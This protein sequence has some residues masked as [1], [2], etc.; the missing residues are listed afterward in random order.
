MQ[1]INYTNSKLIVESGNLQPGTVSW[2]S[3]SNIAIIKYWGKHGVQLPRNP[4]FSFTLSEA[5]SKTSLRYEAK[6][7]FNHEISLQFLFHGQPQPSFEEKIKKYF[8]SLLPYF[9][10]IQQLHFT[11]SSE[12]SFPHSAG[13]ASSASG[14]R[15]KINALLV[16]ALLVSVAIAVWGIVDPQGLGEMSSSIVAIQFESRGWFIMLEASAL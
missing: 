5:H 6:K 12:N 15:V 16:S 2:Q 14:M 13:I 9:P 8:S 7:E 10:F 1:E 4:S 11:I 3:P